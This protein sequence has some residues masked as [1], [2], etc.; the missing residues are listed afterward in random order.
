MFIR[1]ECGQAT[2]GAQVWVGG[3]VGVQK[4]EG[5]TKKTELPKEGEDLLGSTESQV[6]CRPGS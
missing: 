2:C 3:G 1:E 4:R 6:G 5:A